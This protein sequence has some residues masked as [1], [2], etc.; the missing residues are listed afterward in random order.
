MIAYEY[1]F[2][3]EGQNDHIMCHSKYEIHMHVI[4]IATLN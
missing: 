2:F 3:C 4:V 1:D